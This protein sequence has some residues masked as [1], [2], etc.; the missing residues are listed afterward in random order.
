M[1]FNKEILNNINKLSKFDTP[2]ICNGLEIIDSS[3]NLDGYTKDSCFC[4]RP[5]MKPIIGF[6][7][8]ASIS[9]IKSK[10]ESFRKDIRI[11]YYE[12][13]NKGKF[14]KI[15]I[16]EDVYHNPI[17]SFWGEVN[18]NIHLKLGC[19]GVIT[20]G[21]VRDLSVI[22]KKFEMISKKLS[23][24]HADVHLLDYGKKINVLG[25][26]VD[27]NDI[28]HADVHGAVN[29]PMNYLNE[30][31][32]SIKHVVRKEKIILDSCKTNKFN[33]NHFKNQYLKSKKIKL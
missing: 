25:M 19:S 28:I 9:S 27:D 21:S 13:V 5:K 4:L 20:N 15:A 12:Y 1:I 2:T 14:P 30:L 23:P 10:K 16:I 3:F 11:D 18:S 6:A 17:G 32:K 24:S 26:K 33:F 31:L 7:K 29:I 8:T 22:P